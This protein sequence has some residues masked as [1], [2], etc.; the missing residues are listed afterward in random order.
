M[1]ETAPLVSVVIACYNTPPAMLR[2][3]VSSA[4]SQTYSPV[5]VIVVDDGSTDSTTREALDLLAGVHLIRQDNRGVA[6]ARNHGMS[7]ATGD[8][9][10]HSMPTMCSSPATWL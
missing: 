9:F 4:V 3:A 2:E 5:E 7:Q 10:S 1:T 6:A 8:S